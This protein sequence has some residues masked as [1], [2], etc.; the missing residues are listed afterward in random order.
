MKLAA[1]LKDRPETIINCSFNFGRIPIRLGYSLP[2]GQIEKKTEGWVEYKY[3]IR[4]QG[5][6]NGR[7]KYF[8]PTVAIETPYQNDHGRGV[9]VDF[10]NRLPD[11]VVVTATG[12]SGTRLPEDFKV[13]D[14]CILVGAWNARP[15]EDKPE[16]G[17]L[18]NGDQAYYL[19]PS[20]YI[21]G[22][23]S[24]LS[25]AVASE[26]LKKQEVVDHER[27]HELLGQ[28]SKVHVST[29]CRVLDFGAIPNLPGDDYWNDPAKYH[30]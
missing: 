17:F 2:K 22:R 9:L 14:N 12:N 30:Q 13:P 16:H 10:C 5:E 19:D 21:S 23:F 25:T 29:G 4:R 8:P 18:G 27:V 20:L 11:K 26:W 6:E 7:D 1:D 15:E 28:H 3:S 24:S